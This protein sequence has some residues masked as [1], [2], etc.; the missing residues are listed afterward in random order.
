MNT[1]PR[2]PEP[3]MTAI[4]RPDD[5]DPADREDNTMTSTASE[6]KGSLASRKVLFGEYNRYALYAIHIRFDAV[7]WFVA[8]AHIDDGT[9]RPRS[10][11]R[12]TP[13]RRPWPGW[14]S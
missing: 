5:R 14:R 8:A 11:A 6:L 2:T 10:S 7:E 1:A 9:G 4:H 3:K 12:S 13:P